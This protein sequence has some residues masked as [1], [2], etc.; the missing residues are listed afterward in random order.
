M[1]NDNNIAV[2]WLSVVVGCIVRFCFW[3]TTIYILIISVDNGYS[4]TTLHVVFSTLGCGLLMI[5]GTLVVTG[6]ALLARRVSRS[7]RVTIHWVLHFLGIAALLAGFAT[8]EIHK[9]RNNQ[10]HFFSD[11]GRVGLVGYIVAFVVG[12][13]AI[14]TVCTSLL[15]RNWSLANAKYFHIY[16]GIIAFSLLWAGQITGF[17][18]RWW[19][20]SELGTDLTITAYVVGGFLL[21][22]KPF[23][24]TMLR[25]SASST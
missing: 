8:I 15:P 11:H 16:C 19:T 12:V 22:G 2:D 9:I 14:P 17:Y 5:E 20:G 1:K 10:V 24:A 6:D 18:R 4:L 13:A 3:A 23:G 25:S 7:G 21:L